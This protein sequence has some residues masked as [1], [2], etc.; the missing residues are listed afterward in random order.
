MGGCWRGQFFIA[1]V[2]CILLSAFGAICG[3]SVGGGLLGRNSTVWFLRLDVPLRC[4]RQRENWSLVVRGVHHL[5]GLEWQDSGCVEGVVLAGG[6]AL[7]MHAG[8]R[9]N[10]NKREC[11]NGT[12]NH[13]G[14]CVTQ[15]TVHPH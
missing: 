14:H 15:L 2:V 10:S 5:F 6:L 11:K 4:R 12:S 8:D 9:W 13:R 7:G 1:E 3:C